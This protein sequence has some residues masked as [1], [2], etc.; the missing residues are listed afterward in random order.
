MK[1]LSCVRLFATPWTV[2]YYAPP[3]MGFSRQEYWS[4][5]YCIYGTHKVGRVKKDWPR[6]WSRKTLSSPPL[7]GTPESQ[8]LAEQPLVKRPEPI[9]D[10]MINHF[11][12]L[13]LRFRC[14]N[15]QSMVLVEGEVQRTMKQKTW[16]QTRSNI[17]NKFFTKKQR[18]FSGREVAFTL[19]GVG[20]VGHPS[21]KN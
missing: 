21:A 3:P 14:S 15:H 16:K 10:K 8:I 1:W 18:Q 4:G 13:S 17:P 11:L 5:F 6:C 2:A 19:D 12:M 20:V 9:Q 7:L